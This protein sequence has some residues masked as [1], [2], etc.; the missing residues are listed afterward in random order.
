MVR[1]LRQWRTNQLKSIRELAD[2]AG[3]T[4]KTLTDI[5]YGRRRPTFETMRAICKS[6]QVPAADIVEFQAAIESRSQRN[7]ESPRLHQ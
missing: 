6:L 2:D 1:T 3:V 5:E 4:P 7:A